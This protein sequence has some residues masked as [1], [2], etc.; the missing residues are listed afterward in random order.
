MAEM[1]SYQPEHRDEILAFFADVPFKGA[2]WEWEFEQCPGA[3]ASGFHPVVMQDQQGIAGFNGV[4]PV[5][6]KYGDN[7]VDGLWSCDFHVAARVRGQGIGQAIKRNLLTRAPV[8]LSFGV[9]PQ[10]AIVLE[11]MG[12]TLSPD[13][14]SYR[15]IVRGASLKERAIRCLQWVNALLVRVSPGS[16]GSLTWHKTLPAR[17]EVDQLWQR[18]EPTYEKV[19]C[20]T[21]EYL[22]W[23]YQR[24]PLARYCFL[25]ERDKGGGLNGIMVFREH[26]A[27]A[28]LVDYVGPSGDAAML[29]RMMRTARSRFAGA[30][31]WLATTSNGTLKRVLSSEGFFP[32]RSSP[33]LYVHAEPELSDAAESCERGWFVMSGDS[34][35]ELLRAAWDNFWPERA[36]GRNGER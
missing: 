25:V 23:R 24:H 4:V 12:W 3:V 27:V 22:D 34:D 16:G 21:Y 15:R 36:E 14:S 26:D 7:K 33:G 2:I 5:S 6:I 28:R 1:V 35:G 20:R 18:S 19:V 11:K 29:K 13:V 8:I 9:S 32:G 31:L 30:R 10:A 17:E